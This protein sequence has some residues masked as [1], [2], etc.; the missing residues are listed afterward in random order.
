M[1]AGWTYYDGQG[2]RVRPNAGSAMARGREVSV[3]P[4]VPAPADHASLG[5]TRYVDVHV[6]GTAERHAFKS[7]TKFKAWC[8]AQKMRPLER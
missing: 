5:I 7:A 2:N 3:P 4:A 6:I 8:A 1:P